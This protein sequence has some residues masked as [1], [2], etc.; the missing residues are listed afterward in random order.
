[1]PRPCKRRRICAMP[2]CER[3]GPME[4][5]DGAK[6]EIRMTLDEFETIR[7]I[8]LEELT[9]EECARRMNVA[10]TT[11][12]SIY[13]S[14][15]RKLGECLVNGKELHI[16][17]GEYVLCDGNAESCQCK[18]CCKKH[19]HNHPATEE[20]NLCRDAKKSQIQEDL[21]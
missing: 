8:D 5:D 3:F 12:Q 18:Y 13:N 15:R 10:R 11:A 4:G 6:Q 21:K 19:C 7:L 9:Q 20:K 17:G 16:S 14:A 2:G 1:M